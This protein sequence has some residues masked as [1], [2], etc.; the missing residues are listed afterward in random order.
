MGSKLYLILSFL[1]SSL[2]VSAQSVQLNGKVVN[3]KNEPL[4]GV[5]VNVTGIRGI[6]SDVEG[7]YRINLAPGKKY[8]IEFS[9]V[10]YAAKK[11]S[12][13]EVGQGLD[14]E[15]NVV[16]VVSSQNLEGV[17]VRASTRRQESTA[18]LLNFQKNNTALSSGIAA[19]FIRRTP[20]RNT[21]EVLKRVSGASI[22]DN[23]YVI[24]RGLSDRYNQALLNDAVMPSSEPDKKAFSFDIIPSAMIDNIIINKTATPDLPGEFA[25]GL[26]QINTKDIPNKDAISVGLSVGYNTQSTFKDFTSNP[27]NPTDWLGFDNGNRSISKQLASTSDYRLLT[28]AQKIEQTKTFPSNVQ[29]RSKKGD[30]HYWIESVLV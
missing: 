28:D 10:G 5:T 7:R 9:A 15:L 4:P 30:S 21:G 2:I 1:F 12:D 24:I 17:T 27:R 6:T 23:K 3:E 22:Q 8:E 25:G 26:V 18:S 11:V 14:N 20:D 13:I 16:L 19:D 29:G